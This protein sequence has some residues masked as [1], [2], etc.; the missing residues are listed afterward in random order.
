M[1]E[2]TIDLLETAPDSPPQ[3]PLLSSQEHA[4]PALGRFGSIRDPKKENVA[5]LPAWYLFF[6]RN[7]GVA[8]S[9]VIPLED[10]TK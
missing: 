7:V 5:G 6:R 10:F 2:I 9:Y 8:S 4:N 1:A 3:N